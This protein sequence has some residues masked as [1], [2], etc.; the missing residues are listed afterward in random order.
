MLRIGNK[1]DL[2]QISLTGIRALVILGLL[3]NKPRSLEEIR[4][5]FLNYNLLNDS[6]S[7]DILRIDLN[8]LKAMG[9]EI[10]RS[11]ARTNFKYELIKHPFTL[12]ISPEEIAVLKRAYRKIRENMSVETLLKYDELFNKIASQ[13]MNDSTKEAMYGISALKSYKTDLLYELVEDCKYHKTLEVLYHPVAKDEQIKKIYA[14]KLV[15]QNDKIYLFGSDFSSGEHLMLNVKRIIKI[16]T[17]KASDK[18]IEN[19]GT[20]VRFLLKSFGVTGIAEE[21]KIIEK[22]SKGYLIDGEYHNEFLAMQRILSFG[23]SCVVLEPEDFKQKVI[24]KLKKM[25]DIYNE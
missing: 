16:L 25:R 7:D 17:R 5:A 20:K 4:K 15:F 3:I 23:S 21:E 13:T 11:C 2:S 19:E 10:S 12:E 14:E 18:S 8:T 22:T 1:T 24:E 9:C 6:S